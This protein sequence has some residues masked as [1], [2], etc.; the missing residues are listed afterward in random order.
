M[1]WLIENEALIRLTIWHLAYYSNGSAL[2][3]SCSFGMKNLIKT[4]VF[5][6]SLPVRVGQ[7]GLEFN[8][9]TYQPS[10]EPRSCIRSKLRRPFAMQHERAISIKD[11]A[12][13]RQWQWREQSERYQVR[14]KIDMVSPKSRNWRSSKF[15]FAFARKFPCNKLNFLAEGDWN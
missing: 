12:S 14:T 3:L 2:R 7:F 4:Q 15:N 9:I 1:I 11:V 13:F 10:V 6:N 8:Y 5:K